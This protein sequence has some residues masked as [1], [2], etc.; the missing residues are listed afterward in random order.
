MSYILSHWKGLQ[1]LKQSFWINLALGLLIIYSVEYALMLI[2]KPDIDVFIPVSITYFIIFH[3]LVFIWQAVGTLRACDRN[4][5]NYIATG[6]TRAAQFTVIVSFAAVL[7]WGVTLGQSIQHLKRVEQEK[8]AELEAKPTYRLTFHDDQLEI[9]GFLDQGITREVQELL[10]QHSNI[11][12]IVLN[13][14]GGN[15]YEARGLAKII[16][17]NNFSTHVDLACYSACTTAYIAG[18]KRS[19]G[20]NA[21]FGFHQY[22]LDTNKLLHSSVNTEQEQNKDLQYFLNRNISKDFLEKAFSTPFEQMW[23]PEHREL[24]DAGIIH[25]VI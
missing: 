8:L 1:P 15:I 3:V 23:F 12:T 9:S 18:D 17:V 13:S 24:I 7:V 21:K 11:K 19:A 16:G 20:Q 14:E 10:S 25:K 6:W 4:I 2:L 22:K 5:S